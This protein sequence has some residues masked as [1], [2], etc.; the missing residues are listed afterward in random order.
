M[1]ARYNADKIGDRVEPCPT[2]TSTLKNEDKKLFQK[3]QVFLQTK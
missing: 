3:Y 2:P 1:G